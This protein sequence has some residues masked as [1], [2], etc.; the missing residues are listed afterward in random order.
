VLNPQRCATDEP[1]VLSI[2][3]GGASGEVRGW[4]ES[5]PSVVF[6]EFDLPRFGRGFAIEEGDALS[7]WWSISSLDVDPSLWLYTSNAATEIAHVQVRHPSQI[8]DATALDFLAGSSDLTSV[9]PVKL[10]ELTVYH[11]IPTDRYLALQAIDMYGTED[12]DRR[13]TCAAIDARWFV[14]PHGTGDF[15]VFR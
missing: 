8:G 2:D 1:F 15:T 6:D 3:P 5:A 10:G 13:D 12:T 9:G 11:H 7:L 14:A 4:L